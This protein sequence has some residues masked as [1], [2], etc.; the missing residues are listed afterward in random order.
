MKSKV[1]EPKSKGFQNIWKIKKPSAA[2]AATEFQTWADLKAYSL[3]MFWISKIRAKNTS[4]ASSSKRQGCV[5]LRQNSFI[6]LIGPA[7]LTFTNIS[8]TKSS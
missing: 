5:F 6:D 2:T 8:I 3:G 7:S 4:Q 1:K